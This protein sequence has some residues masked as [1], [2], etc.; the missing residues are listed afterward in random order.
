VYI[1]IMKYDLTR[2]RNST[3]LKGYDYAQA[4]AYFVTICTYRNQSLF[5]DISS[6]GEML[7]NTVGCIAF[8]EWEHTEEIREN[9]VLDEFVI[10]P[11]HTHGIIILTGE[12]A[13]VCQRQTPTKAEYG[14]PVPDALGTI[15]GQFKSIVT[16][17]VNKLYTTSNAS[18]WQK[19]YY[20]HIICNERS[21]NSIRRYIQNNPMRW[22]IDRYNPIKTI[23]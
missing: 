12:S 15:M 8:E 1:W 16:K 5:G 13:R 10:M 9:V 6:D 19:N 4:S 20:D 14:K 22:S 3:R 2:N 7:L 17:R 23:T 11:N 18:V 21:L